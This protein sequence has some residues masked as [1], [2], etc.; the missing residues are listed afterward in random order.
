MDGVE[1]QSL[2]FCVEGPSHTA[3]LRMLR[4]DHLFFNIVTQKQCIKKKCTKDLIQRKTPMRDGS[5]V[6][7]MCYWSVGT[8]NISLNLIL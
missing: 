7:V 8:K 6:H 2:M 4:I 1:D 5:L 3:D